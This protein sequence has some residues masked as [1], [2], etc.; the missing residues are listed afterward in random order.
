MTGPAAGLMGSA[1]V[2]H[3]RNEGDENVIPLQRT[4]CDLVDTSA[5]FAEFERRRPDQVFHAAARV[6]GIMG[7]LKN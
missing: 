2:D 5:T 7:S 4:D 6:Y 3:L 1:L